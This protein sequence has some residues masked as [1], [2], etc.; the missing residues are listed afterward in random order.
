MKTDMLIG[1]LVVKNKRKQEVKE[2]VEEKKQEKININKYV[3]TD[4]KLLY[5]II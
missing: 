4:L 1:G 2:N 5:L 3:L